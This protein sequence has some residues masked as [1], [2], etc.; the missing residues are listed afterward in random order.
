MVDSSKPAN[1]E[2]ELLPDYEDYVLEQDLDDQNANGATTTAAKPTAFTGVHATSF[3]DMLLKPELLQSITDCGF[4]HPSDV[5][6]RCIPVAILGQDVLCQAVSGMG[7]TAVFVLSILQTISD[8]PKPC[9]AMILCHTRELAYQIRTEIIRFTKFMKNIRTEVIYGGEPI[10]AQIKMLK[11]LNAPHVVVGTPGRI[12]ALSK[13]N[14]IPMQ[15][16]KIFVLD[17]CDK[18]LDQ[19]GMRRDIQEIFK[20]TPHNKQV[21]MFTATLSNDIKDTCRK[22]MRNPTEVLIENESKLTLHG[23]KQYYVELKA[24]EKIKKL[25]DLIDALDFNQV[26]IF[27][28]SVAYAIKLAEILNKNTI[29]SKSIHR[30][31]PQEERIKIYEGFKQFKHRI[32]VATEIFGRGID[33]EKINIVFNFDMPSESDSYLH[34]VGR[35]GRFGTKGLAITFVESDEDKK[36]LDE[37]QKRFEVKI[38]ELPASIDATSYMNN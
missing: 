18:L 4:E 3:K 7:K 12:L 20:E 35:A 29:P 9:S 34:R 25:I 38:G 6:Q 37:I 5:Q 15:N 30:G 33:I 27:V 17:E 22:F 24:N 32:L 23:L 2:T 21:M 26:I 19:L 10:D 31:V 13:G 14:N 16:M 8:D 1:T 11:G 28:K 36:V